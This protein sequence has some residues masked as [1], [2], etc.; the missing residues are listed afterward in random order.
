VIIR[1]GSREFDIQF[2]DAGDHLARVAIATGTFYEIDLLA[3]SA[4]VC[5]GRK[6]TIVD[7]GANIGNHSIFFGTFVGG[8]VVAIEPNPAAL[9]HL[10]VNLKRHL[11]NYTIVRS[12]V[13]DSPSAGTIVLPPSAERNIGMAQIVDG[14]DRAIPIRTIDEVLHELDAT[15]LLPLP[16]SLV[17]LDIEGMELAALRGA[18]ATLSRFRPHLLVEAQDPDRFAEIARFLRDLGYRVVTRWGKTPMY[19]FSPKPIRDRCRALWFRSRR[20]VRRMVQQLNVTRSGQ[21]DPELP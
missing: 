6:G 2:H 7:V 18:V 8:H 20:A 11:S 19:H 4:F 15:G 10:E 17:K 3:Y 14:G 12:A 16:I 1:Y 9:C 13:S 21:D 5:A